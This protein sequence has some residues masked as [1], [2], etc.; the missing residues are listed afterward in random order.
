MGGTPFS[1]AGA[2]RPSAPA[3]GWCVTPALP[4]ILPPAWRP[5]ASGNKSPT[6]LSD[7]RTPFECGSTDWGPQLRLCNA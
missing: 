2:L 6:S 7:L 3:N 1:V 4:S 5:A